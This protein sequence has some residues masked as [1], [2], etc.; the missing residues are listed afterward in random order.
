MDDDADARVRE[1][2]AR[3][4][5]GG[6]RELV[7]AH[8]GTVRLTALRLTG[9]AQDAED[10]AAE[11]LLRAFRGM[12]G[13]PPEWFADV[14]LRAW[15]L[16]ILLNTWRNELRTRSRRP[17]TTGEDHL[18]ERTEAV[19]P[20]AT[21]PDARAEAAATRTDLA[22]RLAVLT[23]RQREA[24][25]LRHVLDLPIAEVARILD[26]PEGTAKSH[27]SRGLSALRASY[28]HSPDTEGAR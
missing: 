17:R 16:T 1:R 3:D 12:V 24:V 5:D 2:L 10:L 8:G 4:L 26:T 19:G 11:C 7:G 6:F 13:R 20:P 27:V 28:L 14:D 15:L 25:V 23:P 22:A 9:H 21:S 18:D